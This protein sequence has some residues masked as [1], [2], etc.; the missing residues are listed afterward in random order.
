[1][2]DDRDQP[3]HITADQALRDE[4]EGMTVYSGNV[5]MNQGTMQINADTLTIYHRAEEVERVIAEGT[6]ARMQQQPDLE[7]GP[8]KARARVITYYRDEE[9]VRLERE[10]YIERD[11]A[12]VTGDSIDYFIAEQLVKADSDLEEAGS[13]VKVVIPPQAV[14]GDED[15]RGAADGE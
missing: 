5:H 15:E 1:M 6:P 3:I 4:K 10:A 14:Q 8:V 7:K 9:R 13:R 2:P 11:G 12:T